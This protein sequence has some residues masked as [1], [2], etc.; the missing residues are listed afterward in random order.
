MRSL[1]TFG[2]YDGV[3]TQ[4]GI[5]GWL[6]AILVLHFSMRTGPHLTP[7]AWLSMR[8]NTPYLMG[9]WRV[10]VRVWQQAPATHVAKACEI[11]VP[12]S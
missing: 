12:G 9:R 10:K 8:S 6:A 5:N 3:E 4:E 1:D 2:S 11:G 7:H